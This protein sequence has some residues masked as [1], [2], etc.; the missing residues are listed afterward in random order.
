[1]SSLAKSL[2]PAL[3][4]AAGLFAAQ[5]VGAAPVTC[6]PSNNP[7]AT[8]P[9]LPG[10][11]LVPGSSPNTAWVIPAQ[12]PGIPGENEP[13]GEQV[14][15]L[16]FGPGSTF[17]SAGGLTQF[18]IAEPAP[19]SDLITVTTG[20]TSVTPAGGVSVQFTSDPPLPAIVGATLI[21]TEGV[22]GANGFVGLL[23]SVVVVQT[24]GTINTITV[25][26]DSEV[27]FDPF[28]FGADTSDGIRVN[29][30]PEPA[31]LGLFGIALAGLWLVRRKHV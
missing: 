31:S 2:V 26:S 5:S 16:F 1:M 17:A 21:G 20:G 25:A 12:S 6:T 3:S 19:G 23:D 10:C 11:L 24:D 13:N 15:T 29:V 9:Q 28:G 30:V 18:F 14:M 27:G 22:G 7:A 4:L 8:T